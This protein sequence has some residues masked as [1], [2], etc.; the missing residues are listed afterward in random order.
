MYG[1]LI[2]I[3]LNKNLSPERGGYRERERGD[4]D[5]LCVL[6]KPAWERVTQG[7]SRRSRAGGREAVGLQR[8]DG[9]Q[10]LGGWDLVG[11]RDGEVVGGGGGGE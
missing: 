9:E 2:N 1:A 4:K 11:E 3:I 6:H 10:V 7:R 8:W 5:D